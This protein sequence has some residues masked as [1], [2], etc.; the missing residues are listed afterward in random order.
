MVK[1]L[2]GNA[3]EVGDVGSI[4]GLGRSP[5]GVHSNPLQY[6]HLENPMHRGA[7]WA[8]VHRVT[9][10]RTQLKLLSMQHLLGLV[11]CQALVFLLHIH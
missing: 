10:S 11:L 5:G 7:W 4:P 2:P 8:A 6:S 9:K 1:N 3:G